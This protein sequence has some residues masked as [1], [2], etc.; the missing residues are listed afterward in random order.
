MKGIALSLFILI[1]QQALAQD[2]V[3]DLGVS[4]GLGSFSHTS[5]NSDIGV[6]QI[7]VGASGLYKVAPITFVGFETRYEKISQLTDLAEAGSNIRGSMWSPISPVVLIPF[8]GLAL[9]L[10]YQFFGNYKLSSKTSDDQEVVW[11]KASGFRASVVLPKIL[12]FGSYELFFQKRKFKE[13]QIGETE[14]ASEFIDE[15][16]VTT[17]GIEYKFIF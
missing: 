13:Q 9:R 1:F 8:S 3:F 5:F 11:K 17:Y 10:S 7:Q 4:A 2:F 15:P 6:S 14:V 12:P 16:E